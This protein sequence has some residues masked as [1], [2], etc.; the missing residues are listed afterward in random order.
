MLSEE[1]IQLLNNIGFR[2]DAL[3]EEWQE[4]YQQLKQYIEK[5]VIL[6]SLLKIQYLELGLETKGV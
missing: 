4:K 1:R 6:V 2:W 3:E 5:V